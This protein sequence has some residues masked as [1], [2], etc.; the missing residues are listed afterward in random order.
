MM[1]DPEDMDYRSVQELEVIRAQLV[2]AASS[3]SA[4]IQTID[5]AINRKQGQ[6]DSVHPFET[7]GQDPDE[8]DLGMEG[9]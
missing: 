3:L 2:A 7:M 1:I 6:D 5:L 9:R 8:G 4:T